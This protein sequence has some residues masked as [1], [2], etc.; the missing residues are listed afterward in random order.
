MCKK[1]LLAALVA[2]AGVAAYRHFNVRLSM[3]EEPIEAQI[4]RERDKL[5]QL[6][7][8]IKRYISQ[9]AGRE[10]EVKN[11]AADIKKLE[12]QLQ[13]HR[14]ALRTKK[15]ELQAGASAVKDAAKADPEQQRSLREL[16]RLADA[17][18]RGQAELKAKKEQLE[19]NRDALNAAHEELVAYQNERRTLE[20]ELAQL[21]AMLAQTRAEEVKG[22]IHFDKS[23]LSERSKSITALRNRIEVR[24][25]EMELQGRYLGKVETTS[26]PVEKTVF[27][28][29]DE[30]VGA[31]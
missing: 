5:P 28:K 13:K 6:D 17:Y 30:L 16:D 12:E 25:K 21:D 20:T 10:V 27:E 9:V 14:D 2:V 1:V 3:G 24:Q 23:Q 15:A 19:A 8:E 4:K 31:K 26:K 29:V 22:R 7:A 18:A 11:L